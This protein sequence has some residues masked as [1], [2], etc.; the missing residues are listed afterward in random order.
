MF[1]DYAVRLSSLL[2]DAISAI[3]SHSLRTQLEIDALCPEE[4]AMCSQLKIGQGNT[5]VVNFGYE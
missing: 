2:I 1:N 5:E 3:M 4:S